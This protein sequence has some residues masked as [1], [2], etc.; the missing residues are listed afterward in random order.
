LAGDSETNRALG[1]FPLRLRQVDAVLEEFG[2]P[3]GEPAPALGSFFRRRGEALSVTLS[4][5]S[6]RGLEVRAHTAR[7]GLTPAGST[8]RAFLLSLPGAATGF[9]SVCSRG[10]DD[11]TGRANLVAHRCSHFL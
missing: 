8:R 10:A 9:S 4:H 2:R 7:T 1:L 11:G 6:A 5:R 3:L